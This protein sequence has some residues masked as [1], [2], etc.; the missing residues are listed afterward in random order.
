MI[1]ENKVNKNRKR[2]LW[3]KPDGSIYRVYWAINAEFGLCYS[4]DSDYCSGEFSK[5]QLV[6]WG[7]IKR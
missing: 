4:P 1:P 5:H 3:V 7:Y 2:E 6:E